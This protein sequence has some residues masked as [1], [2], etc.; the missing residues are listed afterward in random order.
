[1]RKNRKARKALAKRSYWNFKTNV[2][3]MEEAYKVPPEFDELQEDEN[4]ND[5]VAVANNPIKDL[6]YMREEW[7]AQT[8]TAPRIFGNDIF[9]HN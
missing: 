4:P 1:M 7:N 8:F 3:T 2:E 6:E 5:L 9:P